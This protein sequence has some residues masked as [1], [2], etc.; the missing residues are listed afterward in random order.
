M[1]IS[2]GD[3][4]QL[5]QGACY[6]HSF[7]QPSQ[8]WNRFITEIHESSTAAR[9]VSCAQWRQPPHELSRQAGSGGY[10]C[11]AGASWNSQVAAQCRSLLA[12]EKWQ[13]GGGCL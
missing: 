13:S 11:L 1:S 5:L 9:Q 8:R 7:T 3:Y 6:R 4:S 2:L 12:R 10:C